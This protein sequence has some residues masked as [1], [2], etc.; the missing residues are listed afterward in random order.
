MDEPEAPQPEVM[1]L[2]VAEAGNLKGVGIPDTDAYVEAGVARLRSMQLSNG[3]FGY[4]PGAG[5]AS[6]YGSAYATWVLGRA[7]AAGHAVPEA[8]LVSAQGYL[9]SLVESWSAEA[10][11]THGRDVEI[12]LAL[13]TLAESQLAPVEALTKLHARRTTLPMFARAM[14]LMAI[15]PPK[16]CPTMP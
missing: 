11:P 16:R 8:M 9:I 7:Q 12:A 14:L 5:R 4:W 2:L 10:A 3:G 13:A 15:S 1:L 6:A